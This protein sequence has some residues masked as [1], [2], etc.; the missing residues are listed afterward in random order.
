MFFLDWNKT[1]PKCITSATCIEYRTAVHVDCL[2]NWR[3]VSPVA[4]Q[5]AVASKR[6]RPA[7]MQAFGELLW[8]LV[9]IVAEFRSHLHLFQLMHRRHNVWNA[10]PS[11]V[12][13][14]SLNVLGIALKRL[15]FPVFP[16]VRKICILLVW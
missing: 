14:T 8:T 16:F 2:S 13:F 12:N 3:D 6:G 9:R 15:I 11:T 1:A 10:L 5:I 7:A 4:A